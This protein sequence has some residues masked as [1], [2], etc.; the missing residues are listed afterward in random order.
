MEGKVHTSVLYELCLA[1]RWS[2]ATNLLVSMPA[3]LVSS[4]S[5]PEQRQEE[6]ERYARLQVAH[7]DF[8][9]GWT[10]LHLAA[11]YGSSAKMIES[12]VLAGSTESIDARTM[13]GW[14][15]LIYAAAN[16]TKGANEPLVALLRLGAD[17]RVKSCRGLTAR[18]EAERR[19][20]GV[21]LDLLDAHE[22]SFV[23]ACSLRRIED[24]FLIDPKARH[25]AIENLGPF[26]RMLHELNGINGDLHSITNEI[27]SYIATTWPSTNSKRLLRR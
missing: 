25:E 16:P 23:T 21:T 11:A 26:A 7:R 14:T 17:T 1:R 5:S 2:E 3:H 13:H 27:L 6:Q 4:S 24:Q 12:I 15:P 22:L 9:N 19:N 20:G 18:D 10:A 8:R